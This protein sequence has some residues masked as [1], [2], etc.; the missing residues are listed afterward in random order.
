MKIIKLATL[1]LGLTLAGPSRAQQG[2]SPAFLAFNQVEFQLERFYAGPY[3]RNMPTLTAKYRA[4]LVQQ[5]QDRSDCLKETADPIIEALTD[6]LGDLHTWLERPDSPQQSSPQGKVLLPTTMQVASW[7]LI[8]HRIEKKWL[9]L[10]VLPLSPAA[11]AGTQRGDVFLSVNGALLED[12]NFKQPA[13]IK[14]ELELQRR[15]QLLKVKLQ[16]SV[17]EEEN[18]LPSL[19]TFQGVKYLRIPT[20]SYGGVGL[21]VNALVQQAQRE[22]YKAM[23][24]DVRDNSGG[25]SSECLYAA[26]AFVNPVQ[27]MQRNERTEYLISLKLGKWTQGKRER[28]SKAPYSN[29]SPDPLGPYSLWTGRTLVLVNK[30]TASCAELFSYFLQ[31]SGNIK[32]LGERTLGIANGA[33]SS[34]EL[35][36]GGYFHLTVASGFTPQGQLLPYFIQPDLER[37]DN[38]E[39]LLLTGRDLLLEQAI[40]ELK[41]P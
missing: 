19:Q 41:Q 14:V 40:R 35:F 27:M 36:G 28:N 39:A 18:F 10:E 34:Q 3:T 29:Y 4:Q 20:F 7:G 12:Y 6:E 16:T 31:K 24:V 26:N 9:V 22:G 25:E 33:T 32:V 8:L 5:C 37:K 2:D 1:F 21:K 17:L 38:L 13:R 23:I 11:R 15:G 30:N